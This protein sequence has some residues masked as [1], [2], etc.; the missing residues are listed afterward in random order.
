MLASGLTESIPFICTSAL[1]GQ[2]LFPCSLEGWQTWKMAASWFPPAP[3]LSPWGMATSAGLE[4][5]ITVQIFVLKWHL[6]DSPIKIYIYI[7]LIIWLCWVLI[8]H[9]GS[10]ISLVPL[11]DLL[12]VAGKYLVVGYGI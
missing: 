11:R 2:I 6:Q 1:W 7:I 10:L 4:V 9:A 12:V 5:Y 8:M 3:Q